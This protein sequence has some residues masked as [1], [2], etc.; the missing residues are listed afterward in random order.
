MSYCFYSSYNFFFQNFNNSK[1][2]EMDCFQKSTMA[3]NPI[4]IVHNY[5]GKEFAK[6]R[7]SVLPCFA[8]FTCLACSCAWHALRARVLG[9]L[10]E[11]A[12]LPCFKKL[13]CFTICALGVFNKRVCLKIVKLLS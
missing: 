1:L 4:S 9:V 5:Y 13:A 2:L 3:F 11:I 8:C 12:C 7:A 10:H 6:W